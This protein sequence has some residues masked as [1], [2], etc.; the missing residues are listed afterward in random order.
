MSSILCLIGGKGYKNKLILKNQMADSKKEKK[1]TA[2]Y[3]HTQLLILDF[4]V[5]Y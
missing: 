5:E 3:F 2:M 4:L 1:A